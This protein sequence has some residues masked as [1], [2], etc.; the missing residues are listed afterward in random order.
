M[1]GSFKGFLS[2]SCEMKK[3][4]SNFCFLKLFQVL[5]EIHEKYPHY[6]IYDNLNISKSAG[7]DQGQRYSE[8]SLLGII[9]DIHMLSLTNFVVCTHTSNVSEDQYIVNI[10]YKYSI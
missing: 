2:P 8:I 4:K 5:E 6:T 9:Q 7:I 1:G 10:V 3:K